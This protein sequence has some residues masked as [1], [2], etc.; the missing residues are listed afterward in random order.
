[1]ICS[2]YPCLYLFSAPVDGLEPVPYP[3]ALVIYLG[4]ESGGSGEGGGRGGEKPERALRY[5][6]RHTTNR[7][8]NQLAGKIDNFL[9]I[10]EIFCIYFFQ[11][12]NPS[13]SLISSLKWFA[14]KFVFAKM[15]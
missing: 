11:A 1:M 10:H 5:T 15:V 8:L 12:S 13:G 3:A 9:Q 4:Y 14:E 2:A 6:A 7:Y